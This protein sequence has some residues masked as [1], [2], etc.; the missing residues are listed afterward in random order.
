[1]ASTIQY[2]VRQDNRKNG[3]KLWYGRAYTPN[4]VTLEQVAR[5]IE[6]NASVKVSDVMAFITEFIEC[7]ND[8]LKNGKLV[9]LGKI[10]YFSVGLKSKGSTSEDKFNVKENVVSK[11][12]RFKTVNSVNDGVLTRGLDNGAIRYIQVDGPQKK[13]ETSG[14]NP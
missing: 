6:Q 10:G 12:I 14:S 3:T 8:A 2:Y 1:M 11:H 13:V 4:K 9:K 7:I 5:R